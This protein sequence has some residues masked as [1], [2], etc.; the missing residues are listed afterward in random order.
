[1]SSHPSNFTQL[2]SP[3]VAQTKNSKHNKLNFQTDSY[4]DASSYPDRNES[5]GRLHTKGGIVLALGGTFNSLTSIYS[6][7]NKPTPQPPRGCSGGVPGARTVV[8]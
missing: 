3:A 5:I 4:N 6:A 8:E 1:M 7:G 2:S